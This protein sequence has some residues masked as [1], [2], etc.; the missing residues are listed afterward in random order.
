MKKEYLL[1]GSIA[2]LIF[3]I[4]YKSSSH[5]NFVEKVYEIKAQQEKIVTIGEL[6]KSWKNSKTK[7]R[8]EGIKKY[9]PKQSIKS[10][11]K[12]NRKLKANFVKLSPK[13]YNKLIKDIWNL[14]IKIIKFKSKVVDEKYEVNLECSWQ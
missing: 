1:I 10:F 11:S 12:K 2:I 6:K 13:I 4:F 5:L 7:N 3:S 14:K 8:L 9:I